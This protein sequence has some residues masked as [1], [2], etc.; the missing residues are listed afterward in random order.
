MKATAVL[1]QHH[2]ALER[3]LARLRRDKDM[4]F[5]LVLELIEELLTH[6]SVEEHFFLCPV[7]DA[8]GLRVDTYRAEQA[9]VRNAML[10]AV[11]AEA[12]DET[13]A[14]RLSE[15]SSTFES[16]ANALEQDFLPLVESKIRADHLEAIGNRMEAFWESA[17]RAARWPSRS[18]PSPAATSSRRALT[19]THASLPA[20]DIETAHR[21]IRAR[22]AR[23]A[24]DGR[25][26]TPPGEGDAAGRPS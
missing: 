4:R 22:E 10:Q 17:E 24:S 13:F 16:H 19:S 3:L 14:T 9:A 21:P 1:R 5:T 26:A 18:T 12:D 2:R 11:F 15:L 23:L 20:P 8:T 7:A 25:E 6:L